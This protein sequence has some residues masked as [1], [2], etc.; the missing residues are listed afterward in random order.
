MTS[1][2]VYKDALSTPLLSTPIK[3]VMKI[4]SITVFLTTSDSNLHFKPLF[5]G[6]SALEVL[7]CQCN[8]LFFRFLGK[9]NHVRTAISKFQMIKIPEKRLAMFFEI[10]LIL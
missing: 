4:L 1:G 9:I 5:H 2:L 10:P 7:L 6:D 3:S 8:V